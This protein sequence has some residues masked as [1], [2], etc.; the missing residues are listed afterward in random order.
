MGPLILCLNTGSSSLK[1]TLYIQSDLTI[2]LSGAIEEIGEKKGLFWVKDGKGEKQTEERDSFATYLDAVQKLFHF[3]DPFKTQLTAIGHRVVH[4]GS[5]YLQPTLL[6]DKVLSI[7]EEL[8]PLAPLHLPQEL[9]VIKESRRLFPGVDQ[10]LCFDTSF[11]RAMPESARRF[12][13]P[14][15]FWEEKVERYGFHGLSYEYITSKLEPMPSKAIIAHLGNG[16]SLAAIREGK[17]IDTS[18]GFSPAGGVIMGSRLG[19]IDPGVLIY[20][21]RE[22]KMDADKLEELVYKKSGLLALSDL[23]GDMQTLLQEKKEFAIEM[24][25]QSVAKVI[26]SYVVVLEGLDQLIFTGGIGERADEIRKRICEKLKPLGAQL[27]V[28]KNKE[29]AVNISLSQSAFTIKVIATDEN[30]KIAS[31]VVRSLHHVRSK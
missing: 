4:G 23:T 14:K 29:H 24:F 12:A 28:Q 10:V 11:F 1:C 2:F 6:D 30:Y 15:S 5:V 25:C 20:L 18:M 8:V 21:L 27:D 19:D 13:L 22:K 26:G 3:L 7:L 16:A 17:P 9:E 31:H